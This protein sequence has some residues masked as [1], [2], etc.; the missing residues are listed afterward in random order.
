MEKKMEEMKTKTRRKHIKTPK[1]IKIKLTKKEQSA[2]TNIPILTLI[3]ISTYI[4]TE[5]VNIYHLL[6]HVSLLHH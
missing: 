3:P 5:R 4:L 6:L 2:E 1:K